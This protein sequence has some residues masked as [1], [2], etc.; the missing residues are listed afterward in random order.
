M[1][2]I[3]FTLLF[4]TLPNVSVSEPLR[5]EK[6]FV[7]AGVASP[8]MRLPANRQ[9]LLRVPWSCAGQRRD[10]P[11]LWESRLEVRVAAG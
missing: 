11:R 1:N 2:R 8:T 10:L 5:A 3:Q 9:R 7:I 6:P 4:A